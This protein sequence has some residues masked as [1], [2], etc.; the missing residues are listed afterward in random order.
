M[1]PVFD[2]VPCSHVLCA[3]RPASNRRGRC[4]SLSHEAKEGERDAERKPSPPLCKRGRGSGQGRI[5]AADLSG[6]APIEPAPTSTAGHGF[7]RVSPLYREPS[8]RHG[9]GQR[10]IASPPALPS[11]ASG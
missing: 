11:A 9:R 4:R 7:G 3:T 2:C 10:P 6:G 8:P 1:T 5:V